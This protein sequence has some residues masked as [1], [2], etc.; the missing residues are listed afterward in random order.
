MTRELR[1]MTGWVCQ[2]AYDISDMSEWD[3]LDFERQVSAGMPE[4]WHVVIDPP[5][6]DF[7]DDT[8]HWSPGECA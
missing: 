2:R 1:L 8:A 7:D 4:G 5:D 6:D 3:V